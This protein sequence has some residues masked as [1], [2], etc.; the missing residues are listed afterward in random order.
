MFSVYLWYEKNTKGEN[1][2]FRNLITSL[3]NSNNQNLKITTKEKPVEQSTGTDILKLS[4]FEIDAHQFDEPKPCIED[5]SI[6]NKPKPKGIDMK[7]Q[8]KGSDISKP[9]GTDMQ[10]HIKES[11]PKGTDMQIHNK[12]K[13][14]SD[15]EK[16]ASNQY[17][18]IEAP[19]YTQIPNVIFDCWMEKLSPAEFK[20]ICTICRK[21]FGWRK[22]FD[23]ISL[24]QLEKTTGLSKRWIIKSISSLIEKGLV[25]KSR[26]KTKEGDDD[27][28]EYKINLVVGSEQNTQGGG[29]LNHT[30]P[31][32]LSTHTKERP[33]T[34]EKQTKGGA[35]GSESA[36][37]KE[38]QSSPAANDLFVF[39]FDLLKKKNPKMIE[40]NRKN[41]IADI[42]K[43]MRTDK[44]T[45]DDLKAVLTWAFNQEDD[46]WPTAIQ[47][48]A[49]LSKLFDRA[50][51]KM[52]H[53]S[54]DKREKEQNAQKSRRIEENK[55]WAT[56][57]LGTIR[58][59]NTTQIMKVREAYVEIANGKEWTPIGFGEINFRKIILDKLR[60]WNYLTEAEIRDY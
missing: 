17:S 51:A 18:R 16:L 60:T 21:T 25:I 59:R 14:N 7:S 45:L 1:M 29:N 38:S 19:N 23:H 5:G 6:Y 4:Y 11:E 56:S 26:S 49:T 34:K 20:I 43:I 57:L 12:N 22:D 37:P 31:S 39:F 30:P 40:P 55:A 42:D 44:R 8:P 10:I 46:F 36:K 35:G 2:Y 50:W 3:L 47:S 32:E 53:K 27:I 28:N 41:W 52:N 15:Q 24:R 9:K 58:F 54:K 33:F 48:P 13:Q